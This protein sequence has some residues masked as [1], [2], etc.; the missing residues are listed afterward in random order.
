MLERRGR[1]FENKV[2]VPALKSGFKS[3]CRNTV[4]RKILSHAVVEMT[5]YRVGILSARTSIV[6]LCSRL[7]EE[8]LTGMPLPYSLGWTRNAE[9]DGPRQFRLSNFAL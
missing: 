2:T 8:T 9:I 5:T 6:H 3:E 1:R 4:Y 7:E